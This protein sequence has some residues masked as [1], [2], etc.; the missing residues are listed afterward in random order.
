MIALAGRMLPGSGVRGDVHVLDGAGDVAQLVAGSEGTLAVVVGATLR[1]TELPPRRAVALV[2]LEEIE[3]IPRMVDF[4][5]TLNASACE[6]FGRR[7]VEMA[8]HTLGG[9]L[10]DAVGDAEALVL[11]ELAGEPGSVADGIEREIG[12]AHV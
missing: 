11:I 8:A 5:S 7:L 10:R 4:A 2:A 9:S 12:R 6:L 1:L 3:A